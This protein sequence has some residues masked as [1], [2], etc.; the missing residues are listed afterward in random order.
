MKLERQDQIGILYVDTDRNN[1]IN[2]DFI[3]EA[4]ALMD[5]AENDNSI[6]ALVVTSTHKTIFC[7]GVDLPSMMG[8][9]GPEMRNFYE[10]LTGIVRRKVGYPK[11]E[12]YALNGHTIAAGCMMAL[13]GDYRVMA[14]GRYVFGLMEIDVGLA[15]PVG[16]SEMMRLFFGGRLTE[17]VLFTGERFAPEQALALGLVDEVVE[18]DKLIDRALGQARLLAGKPAGGYRRLKRYSRQALAARMH[19]LDDAH[20]D[21]LVDQWFSEETQ[22]LVTAAVQ[23]MA[24]PATAPAA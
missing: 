24:K 17:R 23:R 22:R 1:A 9:S 2:D 8:R 16:V 14:K 12:I 10:A 7:P 13:A 15:A 4:H 18:P 19:A 11:P 20:L 6:R 5:D 21:E 3:R